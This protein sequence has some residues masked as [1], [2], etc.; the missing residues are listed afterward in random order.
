[1]YVSMH[2]VGSSPVS[3]SF[4]E[5]RSEIAEDFKTEYHPRSGRPTIFRSAEDFGQSTSGPAVQPDEQPWQPFQTV[6][7]LEF[8]D[9]AVQVGLN[10]SHVDALL[11]LISWVASKSAKITFKNEKDVRLACDRAV[12][13]LTPV[14]HITLQIICQFP[15]LKYITCV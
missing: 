14:S 7:D 9:I 10:A 4:Q 6:A 5:S 1:M 8:A 15:M 13:E 2:E 3:L 12:Q 11:G